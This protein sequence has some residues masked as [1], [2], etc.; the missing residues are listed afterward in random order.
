MSIPDHLITP[1][2]WSAEALRHAKWAGQPARDRALIESKRYLATHELI[3]R[4]RSELACYRPAG[5]LMTAPVQ[6]DESP[7]PA[8][9]K[10]VPVDPTPEMIDAADSV[11]WRDDDTRGSVINMWNCMLAVAPEQAEPV[12]GCSDNLTQ[13]DG[14]TPGPW[15]CIL[16]NPLAHGDVV[17]FEGEVVARIRGWGW[18]QKLPDGAVQ[19]DAN[20]RLVAASPDLLAEVRRLT[21]EAAELRRERDQLAARLA[22]I[23]RA[24][25]LDVDII[26]AQRAVVQQLASRPVCN[27]AGQ[28]RHQRQ[29]TA[30]APELAEPADPRTPPPGCRLLGDYEPAQAGDMAYIGA[31]GGRWRRVRPRMGIIGATMD[32]LSDGARVLALAR[33]CRCGP[34]SRSD[35]TSCPR[36]VMTISVYYFCAEYRDDQLTHSMSGTIQSDMPPF[37]EDFHARLTERIAANMKPPRPADLVSVRSLSLL[38][39]R[40]VEHGD[41]WARH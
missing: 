36:G 4:L 29:A 39:T 24:A 20:G 27:W 6:A 38:A 25:D 35:S 21:A 19:Q 30:D 13:F 1:L 41:V 7:R 37:H 16:N 10:A 22:E 2:D 40:E 11:D 33:P 31:I 14:H 9:W 18:L 23:E 32:E 28:C 5:W 17:T 26:E 8:G 3:E 15:Q 34:D 12:G